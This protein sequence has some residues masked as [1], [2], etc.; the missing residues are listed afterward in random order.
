[1][2]WWPIPCKL[3]LLNEGIEYVL[4][5]S[6]L[7]ANM[8]RVAIEWFMYPVSTWKSRGVIRDL[9]VQG[10]SIDESGGGY[11]VGYGKS[12]HELRLF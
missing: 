11:N 12:G 6:Q 9:V 8:L 4:V 2:L 5:N 10:I 7:I 3:Q 1:M